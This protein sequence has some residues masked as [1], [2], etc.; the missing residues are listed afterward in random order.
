MRIV[1]IILKKLK[2]HQAP[3]RAEAYARH[4]VQRKLKKPVSEAGTVFRTLKKAGIP[5]QGSP[6]M[7]A[8]CASGKKEE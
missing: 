3:R 2:W 5:L 7:A 6:P 8:S 4:D 1:M